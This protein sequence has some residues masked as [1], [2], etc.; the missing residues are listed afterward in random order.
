MYCIA[1]EGTDEFLADVAN[2]LIGKGMKQISSNVFIAN[3]IARGLK[4]LQ[5]NNSY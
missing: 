3:S 2:E 4:N 1:T 5:N